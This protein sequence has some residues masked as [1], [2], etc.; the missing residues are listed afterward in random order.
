MAEAEGGPGVEEGPL[1]GK[2]FLIDP[3]LVWAQG[4]GVPIVEDFGVDLHKVETAPWARMDCAGA[5]V[6]LKGRGDFMSIFVIDLAP[7][8]KSA[9]Q[10]HLFEEVIYVLS[11][12]GSTTITVDG[13]AH[14]FE[15]GPNSLFALP[16]N[17]RYQHFNGSGAETA[18]LIS[19]NDLTIMINLFHDEDF[20][21]ENPA[22]F[23]GRMGD[24]GYF[25]GDG[26][27]IETQPG[28]FMWETNFVPDVAAFK[29]EGW[30]Q[31][32]ARSS[33]MRF[34]L[35]DGVMHVHTSEMAVGTYKKGHRHGP[36]FH[37]LVL[38]GEGHSLF[39]Y[40]NDKDFTRIDWHPGVVFAPPD[41]MFHQH[42][43][44]SARPARYMPFALGSLRYPLTADK[45]HVF[46]GVDVSV[47]K[48]GCQ[49]DYQDQDPRIHGIFLDALARNGV[50]SGMGDYFD[51][52]AYAAA[53]GKGS[54]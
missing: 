45:R 25:E 6:H 11:G 29:L 33:N 42:F 22:E 52:S 50:K 51:E 44:T 24:P 38:N 20:I 37:V 14:S 49:I 10:R 1:E 12:H 46:L 36:D 32:G 28:R 27:M 16:L 40:E 39:W 3:Y 2:G 54:G 35:A 8:A 19:G 7:G 15:W 26:K 41:Q 4:E 53:S 30:E 48:G 47:Q 17:A 18:R 9:P 43:N 5:F 31:R 23:A 34:A 21:F 13:E